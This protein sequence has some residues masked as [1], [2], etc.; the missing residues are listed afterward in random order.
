MAKTPSLTDQDLV[1]LK[2]SNLAIV[3]ADSLRRMTASDPSALIERTVS[4]YATIDEARFALATLARLVIADL[5]A[6]ENA[7]RR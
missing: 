6:H 5:E 1:E 3:I 2:S 4:S 7:K